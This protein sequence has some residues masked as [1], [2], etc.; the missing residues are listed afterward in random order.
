MTAVATKQAQAYI[1]KMLYEQAPSIY[2]G[3]GKST[4]WNDENNVPDNDPTA[5]A[6]DE[7][8]A[9]TKAQDV[10]LCTK[11]DKVEQGAITVGSTSYK[12]IANTDEINVDAVYIYAASTFSYEDLQKDTQFR[13]VG[14]FIGFKPK[15]DVKNTI[16]LP[17]QVEKQGTLVSILNSKLVNITKTSPVKVGAIYS[18]LP[19]LD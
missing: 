10:A 14:M 7:P 16:I 15:A 1:A 17:T 4:P 3:L 12:P 9:Y 13:Q 8:I 5:T 19:V 2:L 6:L 11:L 18:I